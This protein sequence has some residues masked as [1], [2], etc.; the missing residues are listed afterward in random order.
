VDADVKTLLAHNQAVQKANI[1]QG[2]QHLAQHSSKP[3]VE[4]PTPPPKQ[5]IKA[6]DPFVSP[7][8]D[9]DENDPEI[10]KNILKVFSKD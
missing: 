5:K 9:I 1:E 10:I 4:I 6:T 8:D 2:A 3:K 7:L